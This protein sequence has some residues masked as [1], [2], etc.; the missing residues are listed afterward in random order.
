DSGID[1][2]EICGTTGV[3]STLTVE[4]LRVVLKFAAQ[5]ENGRVPIIAGTGSNDTAYAIDMTKYACELGYDAMLVVTPYYNKTTQKGLIAMFKAIADASTKP[6]ILY[7]EAGIAIEGRYRSG[8]GSGDASDDLC[9]SACAGGVG[10][11]R[12]ELFQGFTP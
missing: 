10:A 9:R 8:L 7:N 3:A 1:A 6:L 11:D 5:V 2:L 12:R 4:E